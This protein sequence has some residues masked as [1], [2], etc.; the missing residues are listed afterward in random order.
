[1]FITIKEHSKFPTIKAQLIKLER[2]IW[3]WYERKI[4]PQISVIS[5]L[6]QQIK[7]VDMSL[8]IDAS[9]ILRGCR[10][11]VKYLLVCI[12]PCV[13][14]GRENSTSKTQKSEEVMHSSTHSG[15]DLARP[16]IW[17]VQAYSKKPWGFREWPLVEGNMA[18]RSDGRAV[19]GR[20]TMAIH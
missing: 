15:R 8:Y 2:L 6:S 9:S 12:A 11:L 10:R 17:F 19:G 7:V 1:M 5:Y 13:I 20:G 14:A 4:N 3:F 18:S 16:G